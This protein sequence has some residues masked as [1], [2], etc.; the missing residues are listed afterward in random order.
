MRQSLVAFALVCSAACS[1]VNPTAPDVLPLDC[2]LSVVDAMA[3]AERLA[4]TAGFERSHASDLRSFFLEQYRLYLT[5][6][7][8][9]PR[10]LTWLS[11]DTM[12]A[13]QSCR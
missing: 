8:G 10:L 2:P 7:E 1:S 11:G 6:E 5:A 3:P 9:D 12:H 4:L 13:M